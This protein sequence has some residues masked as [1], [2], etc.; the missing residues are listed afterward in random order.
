MKIFINIFLVIFSTNFLAAQAIKQSSPFIID[1]LESVYDDISPVM[2]PDGNMLFFTKVQHPDNSGGIKDLGDIWVSE[3]NSDA[4]EKPIRLKGPVNNRQ[5]NSV[6]GFTSDGM[7]MYV[8]GNYENYIKGGISYSRKIGDGWSEPQPID[9][10]YFKNKSEHISGS[11]SKD[12]NVMVLSLDS[13]GGR[14]NEDIYYTFR[15]SIDKWTELRNLGTDINT[16]SQ[17]FSP[18]LASDNKT[19]FFSSNGL[20]GKGSRDVFYAKRLDATWTAWSKPQNISN[21][22]SEGADWYF[23]LLEDSE[24]AIMV[25]T[26]NSV[27]LGNIMLVPKPDQIDIEP[28]IE[29]TITTSSKPVIPY[30]INNEE[31]KVAKKISVKFK[32][33]DALTQS[34]LNPQIVIK[35]VNEMKRSSFYEIVLSAGSN[36][37]PNL[38]KDSVYTID[39][40]MEGYLDEERSIRTDSISDNDVVVFELVKIEK[41][42]TIQLKSVLFERGTSDIIESSYAELDRVVNMLKKNENVEI[43]LAGHTDNTGSSRLNIK[44]SQERA[45]AIQTY[46]VENGVEVSRLKSK[47]YGGAKPIASNRSEATRQ[48]NRRVEFTIIKN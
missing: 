24:E 3:K 19:L 40:N 4:W 47:G 38:F 29:E 12:G 46:L 43:E 27:G 20:G 21:L 44:L 8:T 23:K 2:H 11:L 32:V 13:Y 31:N 1:S 10:P 30:E 7:I 25:N 17:E 33:I 14:G 26:V 37:Q 35:G 6:I 39:I 16:A 28:A 45:D 36:Y 9:I 18:Y 22:N 42:T 15:K 5:F 48:L 34:E 41:G